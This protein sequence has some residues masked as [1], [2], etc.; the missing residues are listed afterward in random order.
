[1]GG[2]MA[3]GRLSVPRGQALPSPG[4]SSWVAPEQRVKEPEPA[5]GACL[6]PVLS[7]S[8]PHGNGVADL[9]LD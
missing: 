2:G 3:A 1:M 9:I 5:V 6:D 8:T 7:D 4:Q